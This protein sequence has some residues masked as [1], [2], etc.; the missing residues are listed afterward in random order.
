MSFPDPMPHG[1]IIRVT[2]RIHVVRG[3]FPIGPGVRIGRTMTH[4]F[5]HLVTGHGPPVT[6]GAD[7]HAR[8]AVEHA[9]GG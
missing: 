1:P 5:E 3:S 4:S 9:A 7:K 8:A 2:D 6:G